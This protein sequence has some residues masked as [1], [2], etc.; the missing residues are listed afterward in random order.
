[1]SKVCVDALNRFLSNSEAT[2]A[3]IKSSFEAPLLIFANPIVDAATSGDDFDLRELR[4][5]RLSIYVGIQPR[6]LESASRLL[7]VFFSQ[8]VNLNT[9]VLPENDPALKYQGLLVMDEFTS[10]GR[11]PILAKS[12][13]FLAGYGLRLMPIVQSIEQIELTYGKEAARN[14]IKNHDVKIVFPPDDIE[15]AEK[16]SRTLGYCTEKVVS[17]GESRSAGW[18]R[19]SNRSQSENTSDQRRALL[20]PQEVRELAQDQQIILKAYCKPI[21]CNKIRYYD[22][23]VFKTRLLPPCPVAA[24]NMALHHAKTQRRV[25]AVQPGEI[26]GIDLNCLAINADAITAFSGDPEN[27]SI[28]EASAVVDSFFSQLSWANNLDS[29]FVSDLTSHATAPPKAGRIDLSAL[30]DIRGNP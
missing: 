17:T 14:F 7:N 16:V 8:L 23:P 3:G 2:L 6:H 12:V 9:D 5:R 26:N 30:S 22:D 29:N 21:L 4:R 27:P 10:I 24:M 1:L 11:I 15:D 25:R 13:A 28:E 19:G 18:S 20:L